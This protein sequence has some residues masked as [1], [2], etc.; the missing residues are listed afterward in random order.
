M[1]SRLSLV[2]VTLMVFLGCGRSDSPA[3]TTKG[4]A[5]LFDGCEEFRGENICEIGEHTELIVWL[6]RSLPAIFA[7]NGEPV[8]G[9][10]SE[11][12]GSA[13]IRLRL[14]DRARLLTIRIDAQEHSLKLVQRR[15]YTELDEASRLQASGALDDAREKL[16]APV[17][18]GDPELRARALSMRARL[19]IQAGRFAD[20]S[21]TLH[22]SHRAAEVASLR[23]L[24]VKELFALAHTQ[25][26][27]L[28]ELK[29]AEDT[30]DLVRPVLASQAGSLSHHRAALA[31]LRGDPRAAL[32][33]ARDTELVSERLGNR[34][35]RIDAMEMELVLL[36]ELGRLADARNLA[37]QLEP[38]VMNDAC[39]R[40]LLATNVG[41]IELVAAAGDSQRAKHHSKEA[42]GLYAS[43]CPDHFLRQNALVNLALANFK[44][45]ALE[46]SKE[47]LAQAAA[48]GPLAG[49]VKAWAAELEGR[50]ALA[51]GNAKGALRVFR[52]LRSRTAIAAPVSSRYRAA[53]GVG[54]ALKQLGDAK[55]AVEAF[56]EAE[57]ELDQDARLVPVAEGRDVF[58]GERDESSR[59]LLDT[60]LK[61]DRFEDALRV[62][63]RA[64][65]RALRSLNLS[66]QAETLAAQAHGHWLDATG[67]YKTARRKLEESEQAAWEVPLAEREAFAQRQLEERQDVER[68]L[69]Q[70]YGL[71]AG[72]VERPLLAPAE[73]ELMLVF[74]SLPEGWVVFAATAG[75]VYAQRTAALDPE[76]RP[77][78][79]RQLLTPFTEQIAAA[80][81]VKI[82]PYGPLK[83]VPFH[84]LVFGDSTLLDH[85]SVVYGTDLGEA[86]PR[87]A[88]GNKIDVIADPRN[89]LVGARREGLLIASRALVSTNHQWFGPRATHESVS[90]AL[91]NARLVHYAGHA[92][93]DARGVHSRLLLAAGGE[94]NVGD[95]L[96]LP[97]V[98]HT[99]V[100]SGC[101]TMRESAESPVAS[102]GLAQALIARGAQL[103]IATTAPVPDTFGL[104]LTERLYRDGGALPDRDSFRDALLSARQAGDDNWL[105]YRALV[106]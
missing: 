73:G 75:K 54:L 24:A 27:K 12:H 71:L 2:S 21:H 69:D 38:L 68:A 64:R 1:R 51:A 91:S 17:R 93:A 35:I 82:L 67:R 44:Q 98:P 13:S 31:L 101:E 30:L 84:G 47:Q 97:S 83:E 59:E 72:S 106:P 23:A 29:Q 48:L 103:V 57:S 62:A 63:R 79:S 39:S 65:A 3:P 61:L 36:A 5:P 92:E 78:L 20:A 4:A 52:D 40:A 42:E 22:Q 26:Q 87:G 66:A 86:P 43:T 80:K 32:R 102:Y 15:R 53:V 37:A 94:L 11:V 60:L 95:I 105:N 49:W 18:S 99:V 41:W 10:R 50:L 7:I 100:L 88:F 76:N 16:S 34:R 33:F 90:A 28:F 45:G 6:P 81:W 85:K 56:L 58:V 77:E 104:A 55:G 74:H 19:E 89:D 70:T 9:V 46:A 96:M 8:Q 14:T 25:M